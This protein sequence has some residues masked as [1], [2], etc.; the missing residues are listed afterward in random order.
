MAKKKPQKGDPNTKAIVRGDKEY[1]YAVETFY[2]RGRQYE[3]TGATWEKAIEKK[4]LKIKALENGDIGISSK[5]TVKRWA[6]EWLETYKK[7][8]V[9]D[10]SYKNYK[11]HVN[12]ISEEIGS[13]KINEVND[14]H[15]QKI[16]NSREGFSYSEAK[17]LKDTIK[18]IFKK[19]RA[20]R[21]LL[22]DPAEFLEMP[23]TKKGTHRSVT[24]T[25][26]SWIFK[27][28]ETHH[29]GLWVKMML[30]CGLRP[31]ECMALQWKDIDFKEKV[32][33]V[34]K[35][36]ESGSNDIKSPKTDAGERE[37]PIPDIFIGDLEQAAQGPFK[38]VFTQK[39]NDKPHTESS[40]YKSWHNFLREM[41]IAMGAILYRNRII[42]SKLEL[43]SSGLSPLEP[44][45]LRHT[46]C[47]DLRDKGIGL[48]EAAELMGHD[49]V[50][51]TA[52]IYT[53]R[54]N[55]QQ[56]KKVRTKMNKQNNR[57]NN[58]KKSAS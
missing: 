12:L 57:N 7:P 13:L 31:G 19:A 5:M 30:Y 14:M 55:D 11:R 34:Q 26:R 4:T 35:A 42:Q 6:A 58:R 27:T 28:A 41:D 36:K 38:P 17:H 56:K 53:H 25:E 9:T 8:T 24:E 23:K 1:V 51:V 48:T 21:L 44:Y 47:T 2:W 45:C 18:A 49:D 20:S 32:V 54:M 16:L 22:Y 39:T 40:F 37:I 15:L 52:N 29:A 43:I 33:R 3:V 50:S 10:K 46:F